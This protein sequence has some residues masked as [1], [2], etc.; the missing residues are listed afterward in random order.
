MQKAGKKLQEAQERYKRTYDKR[1]RRDNQV[2]KEDDYVCLRVERKDD[3]KMCHK[4]APVA[5]GPYLVKNT[6]PEDKT[7]TIEYLDG[8][9]Q[10]V[11]R[12][13]VLLAPRPN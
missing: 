4:L 9:A 13:R 2:I 5:A 7:V 11:S 3:K 8:T 10:K 6:S 12:S 1:L